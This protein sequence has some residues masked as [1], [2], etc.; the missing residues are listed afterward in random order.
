MLKPSQNQKGCK[1]ESV[2]GAARKIFG[3]SYFMMALVTDVSRI[4][5][6]KN[7]Q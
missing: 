4:F 3:P 6:S 7:E 1:K 2:F 5:N